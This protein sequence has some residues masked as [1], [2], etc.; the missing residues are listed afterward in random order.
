MEQ[1]V[2]KNWGNSQGI[3]LPKQIT[4][5]LNINVDDVLE[6]KIMDDMIVLKKTFKHKSF[7]ERLAEYDGKI[8]VYNYEWG[9]PV[10]REML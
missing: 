7:S 8:S 10:G 2:V 5:Q 4:K 9:N 3:R 6:V 1:L